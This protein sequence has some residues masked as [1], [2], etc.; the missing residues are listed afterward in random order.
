VVK[1]QVAI[2][3]YGRHETISGATLA[4]LE[5]LSVPDELITIFVPDSSQLKK[6]ESRL[7]GRYRL[8]VAL[9]GKFKAIQFYHRWYCE[10]YGEG[11]PLVQMDDDIYWLSTL[12]PDS[13]TKAGHRLRRHKGGLQPILETGFG[14]AESVGTKL[15]GATIE[16]RPEHMTQTALVGNAL[17]Y[18]GLQGC[19]AGD[20]IFVG[21]GRQYAESFEEDSETSLQAFR[22]YGAVVRL[23][24]LSL[25][26][27]VPQPGGIRGELIDSGLA[28]DDRSAKIVRAEANLGAFN[29]IAQR[30]PDLVS[31]VRNNGQGVVGLSFRG[32]GN[33]GIP[34]EVVEQT[35][36]NWER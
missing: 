22:K 14:L 26:T 24:Y 15:W 20:S 31:V 1:Y 34:R 8:V 10:N 19:Y 21:E 13:N 25:K 29:T 5:S 9:P 17:I 36:G 16:S 11:T 18:G 23:E 4:M 32:E 2:P 30:Y 6:Y 3:S 35:F 7:G 28:P 33:V 27:E 12:F